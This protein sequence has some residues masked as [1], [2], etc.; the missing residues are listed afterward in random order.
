MTQW[1]SD[2]RPFVEFLYFIASIVLVA[3]IFIGIR[4]LK[5]VQ[6]DMEVRY[7]RAAIEKSI[8]YLNYFATEFIPK[9][10]RFDNEMRS[11][12]ILTYAGPYNKEFKFDIHCRSNDENIKKQIDKSIDHG[13]IDLINELEYFS[14]AMLSGLADEELAFNPLAKIFCDTVESHYVILC[15]Q[16]DEDGSNLYSNTVELYSSWK[17]RLKKRALEMERNKIDQDISQIPDGRIRSIG[18]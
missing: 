8:E 18:G 4:Q 12:A 2:I 5:L 11:E 1:I 7:K 17:G 14:A 10:N 15:D 6:R 3:G 9:C 13:A 16:R